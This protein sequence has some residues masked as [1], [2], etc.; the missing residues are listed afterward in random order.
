MARLLG[1]TE[2]NSSEETPARLT[3]RYHI[4]KAISWSRTDP[5][6]AEAQQP[7]L[8]IGRSIIKLLFLRVKEHHCW[9][10]WLYPLHR[11]KSRIQASSSHN[12]KQYTQLLRKCHQTTQKGKYLGKQTLLCPW[13]RENTSMHAFPLTYW[14]PYP[15]VSLSVSCLPT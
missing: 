12:T 5:S 4:L 15:W 7:P 8:L 6:R 10:T 14:S 1:P 9:N 3:A 2:W 11:A 13:F